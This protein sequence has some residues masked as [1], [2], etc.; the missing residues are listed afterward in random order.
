MW[1]VEQLL[2][3]FED[4]STDGSYRYFLFTSLTL[5]VN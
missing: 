3:A 1:K 2:L 5:F 4:D